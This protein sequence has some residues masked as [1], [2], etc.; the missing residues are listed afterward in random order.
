MGLGVPRFTARRFTASP[1]SLQQVRHY[2]RSTLEQWGLSACA[3]DAAMVVNELATNALRHALSRQE[4]DN[5]GWLGLIHTANA[6]TCAVK[7]PSPLEPASLNADL[8]ALRGRGLRIVNALTDS[9]G[10]SAT[11]TGKTV[12]ARLQSARHTAGNGN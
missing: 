3:D 10:Y 2:T 4:P 11:G 12:W 8:L 7:D 6:V 1:S 5:A 9:W